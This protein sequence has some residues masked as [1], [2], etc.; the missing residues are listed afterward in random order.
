MDIVNF[1]N[2]FFV[3]D[4][5]NCEDYYDDFQPKDG[6]TVDYILLNGTSKI[7]INNTTMITADITLNKYIININ[8]LQSV[9]FTKGFYNLNAVFSNIS[10]SKRITK[11]IKNI[12]IGEDLTTI[13]EQ[14]NRSWAEI[15][16]ENLQNYF[17]NKNNYSKSYEIAGRKLENHSLKELIELENYLKAEVSRI[18]NKNNK[19]GNSKI[20]IQFTKK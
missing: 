17:K 14:E 10:L 11:N 7:T 1:P 9:N 13:T 5:I 16:L 19:K 15:A 8:S 3:G 2:K 6:W 4:S 20:Y 12:E 18:S